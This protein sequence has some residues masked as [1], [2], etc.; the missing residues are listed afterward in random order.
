MLMSGN[1]EFNQRD[2]RG[3]LG[4]THSLEETKPEL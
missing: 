4:C 3:H 2:F 1:V